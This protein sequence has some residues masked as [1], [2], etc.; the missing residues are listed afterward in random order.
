VFDQQTA[1][2]RDAADGS[3]TVVG[4][5]ATILLSYL[6]GGQQ[7]F[8]EIVA[9]TGMPVS[10]VHRLVWELT[11]CRI[12]ERTESGRYRI[13]PPLRRIAAAHGPAAGLESRASLVL[14]D[15]A[16]ALDTEVRLG[17]LR[18]HQVAYIEAGPG[19][20]PV[21]T[22]RDGATASVHTAMGMVLLAFSPRPVVDVALLRVLTSPDGD[23]IP[24]RDRLLRTLERTRLQHLAV[25]WNEVEPDRSTIAVP[26][27]KAG[28][29]I[30]GALEIRVRNPSAQPTM[31]PA[32]VVAG[33]SL[34]RQL[35]A[36]GGNA[37]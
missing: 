11:A 24:T 21:T 2:P 32:L 14:H 33:R 5:A 36:L 6:Y 18:K 8:T 35:S 12:L 28:G 1:P 37:L 29:L 16:Q 31:R 15:L 26:V 30:A 4:K 22:F 17:V 25:M 10:T 3:R 13:A 34:T 19:R 9:S 20:R 27:F 7:T 23:A